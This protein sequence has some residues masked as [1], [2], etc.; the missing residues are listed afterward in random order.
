MNFRS[1]SHLLDKLRQ[2]VGDPLFVRCGRGIAAT[3]RAELLSGQ[4]RLL[5]A[6]MQGFA[7]AGAFD[8]ARLN[9]T[10]T[11]A[12]NDLQRDLLLPALLRR[13][14]AQAPGVNLRVMDSGSPDASL[15]RDARCQLLITPRPPDAGDLV[16]KRLFEDRYVVFFDP[17]H[18]ADPMHQWL[19]Q[20]VE[21]V[22][23][24]VLPA[25]STGA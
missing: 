7:Q 20:Q 10:L 21:A 23:P 8:H 9:T 2:I 22:V 15:L 6:Q 17:S 18:Q 25:G 12:A 11:L 16:Q 5:L 24:E 4:A 1:V 3:A 14:R 19:R 13:L